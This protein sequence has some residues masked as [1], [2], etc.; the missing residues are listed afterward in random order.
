MVSFQTAQKCIA[1]GAAGPFGFLRGFDLDVGSA[2]RT[3]TL[4]R[5]RLKDRFQW[6]KSLNRDEKGSHPKCTRQT[7]KNGRVT[8]GLKVPF[9]ICRKAFLPQLNR[10]GAFND[11]VPRA[12]WRPSPQLGCKNCPA[13]F[14]SREVRIK[15]SRLRN[16]GHL[17]SFLHNF[18]FPRVTLPE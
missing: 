18:F 5:P 9:Q 12:V 3:S 4:R 1:T 11:A 16:A 6:L 13:I 10:L 14:H 7:E 8:G 17:F 15:L 2:R